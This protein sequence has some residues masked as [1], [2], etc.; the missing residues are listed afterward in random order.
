MFTRLHYYTLHLSFI[1]RMTSKVF[2]SHLNFEQHISEYELK[3]EY[4]MLRIN[5]AI[6]TIV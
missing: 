1:D 2:Y 5:M 4:K 3:N 6:E